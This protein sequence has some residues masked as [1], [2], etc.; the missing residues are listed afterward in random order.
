M[1]N[2]VGF[3][4]GG[5]LGVVISETQTL[6]C[7]VDQG[8]ALEVVRLDKLDDGFF[9]SETQLAGP[10]HLKQSP[11]DLHIKTKLSVL[12]FHETTPRP[13]KESE[14][15]PWR[16]AT[17]VEEVVHDPVDEDITAFDGSMGVAAKVE[18]DTVQRVV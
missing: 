4:A 14:V 12:R 8:V 17:G 2:H 9:Q 18:I 10:L 3:P 16:Y 15:S 11:H 6:D 7:L 13:F 5:G 1:R